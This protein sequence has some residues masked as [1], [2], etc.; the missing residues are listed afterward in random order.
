[1]VAFSARATSFFRFFLQITLFA[2]C[3]IGRKTKYISRV[4]FRANRSVGRRKFAQ[5]EVGLS[6]TLRVAAIA[7]LL[8]P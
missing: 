1:M 6:Q 5:R 7:A 8:L 3:D 4:L 2:G